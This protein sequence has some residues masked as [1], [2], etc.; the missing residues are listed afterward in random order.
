MGFDKTEPMV[1]DYEGKGSPVGSV[2]CCSILEDN[3]DL[4]FLNNLG[5]KFT[6]L[7][8]EICGGR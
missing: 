2:G 5:P 4:E 3:N 6:T 1:Y 7:A 8:D